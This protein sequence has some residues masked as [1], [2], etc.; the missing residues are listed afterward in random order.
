MAVRGIDHHQIDAGGDQRLGAGKA[1]VADG[2]GGGDAQT[3]LI[4]L[5]GIGIGHRLL[6]VL[7]RDEADA[8]VFVVYHQQL[9]DAALV[10]QL[11]GLVLADAL[12]HGDELV[13]GH[14]LGDRLPR[15]GG[16]AHVAVGED[17]DQLAG[18]A[19]FR[20]LNHRNAGNAVLAHQVERLLQRCGGLN[21]DRVY[22]H[23][24]LE[25]LH[26]PHLGGLLIRLEIA[27]DDADAAGL[28][29][30]D[31]HFRLGDGIHGGGDD[32]DIDGNRFGDP[33]ADIGLGRHHFGQAG[34]D[35]HVVESERFPRASVVFTGHRQLRLT[36]KASKPAAE[37]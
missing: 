20:G 37:G 7:H 28:R 11:L 21:G 17:A 14:Q 25:L 15:I 36:R 26:L 4:V 24:G 1:L 16:K 18:S 29:H 9:L 35:Q 2:R 8:A 23:A 27:V 6:D 30:G 19:V 5:A 13:L 31:R 22:D 34:P 3:A 32:W 12:A 33:G 10:Q